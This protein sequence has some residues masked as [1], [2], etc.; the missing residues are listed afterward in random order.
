[1]HTKPRPGRRLLITVH[2]IRTF[3][4]W[5]ERLEA[6]V[7]QQTPSLSV[8]NYKYGYFSLLAFMF[9]PLRWLLT[10]RFQRELLRITTEAKWKR[11][12]I[13]AHSF[14]SH[15]VAWSLLKLA[16]TKGPKINTIIFCGSVL[17]RSFPWGDLVGSRVRRVVNDCGMYDWVLA[18]NQLAVVFTGMAGLVGFSGMTSDYF[19][20][21]WYRFGHS[22]FFTKHGSPDDAFMKRYWVPLLANQRT[23]RP[24]DERGAPGIVSGIIITLLQNAEPIKLSIYAI[25]LLLPAFYFYELK[26]TAE[27]EANI[28]Q[29]SA[30]ASHALRLL[31]QDSSRSLHLAAR[32]F[33][34]HPSTSTHQ[35]LLAARYSNP[36]YTIIRD[37]S[38]PLH[39]VRIS[40][41]GARIAA[42]EGDGRLLL[43]DT[44]GTEVRGL[45]IKGV[46]S[47]EWGPNGEFIVVST[48]E[49]VIVLTRDGVEVYSIDTSGATFA[50]LGFDQDLVLIAAKKGALI[51]NRIESKSVSLVGHQQGINSVR[52]SPKGDLVVTASKD[53]TVRVWSTKGKE[54]FRLE[55]DSKTTDTIGSLHDR[56]TTI[57][58]IDGED[59]Y[60][61][62]RRTRRG[63]LSVVNHKHSFLDAKFNFE[64]TLIATCSTDGTASVWNYSEDTVRSIRH[65]DW[66]S[67]VAFV[68]SSGMLATASLDTTAR[69]WNFETSNVEDLVGHEDF[70]HAIDVLP[71]GSAAITASEDGTL[72]LWDLSQPEIYMQTAP[73]P[74]YL[75][76]PLEFGPNGTSVFTVIRTYSEPQGPQGWRM[77]RYHLLRTEK[78]QKPIV[79]E[80]SRWMYNSIAISWD[81]EKVATT[82]YMQGSATVRDS[83]GPKHFGVGEQ[84]NAQCIAISPGNSR[85]VVGY[86]GGQMAIFDLESSAKVLSV[87]AHQSGFFACKFSPSGNHILTASLDN[88]AKVWTIRGE[89]VACLEGHD[90]WV[91]A[92]SMD[93]ESRIAATASA[94][95][96]ARLWNLEGEEI[97]RLAGHTESVTDIKISPRKNYVLTASADRTARLWDPAGLQ[98]GAFSRG[99]ERILAIEFIGG[100][101]Q[102]LI[103]FEDGAIERWSIDGEHILSALGEDFLENASAVTRNEMQKM[104][105][106]LQ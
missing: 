55:G 30:I 56:E 63:R 2:G 15:L 31:D 85:I 53:N 100:D 101:R 74:E 80:S 61:T 54:L 104:G 8:R 60:T 69:L 22:G 92:V 7:R 3:G 68:G 37:S 17:K 5:Q 83:S 39:G 88:T 52:F 40:P 12:D 70:I 24:H 65:N 36:L 4:N 64:G 6:L 91:Q 21:R 87:D 84:R 43:L 13:V 1:M 89:L 16:R 94:D 106:V 32:A 93:S 62:S 9:P 72:R 47:T 14:G 105:V 71:D 18:L 19:R 29:A 102:V 33:Q 51:H 35:T 45:A 49:K 78:G 97:L 86:S 27:E 90:G 77:P 98:L 99:E 76:V 81:E 75:E 58:L 59:Q 46:N 103:A 25:V 41:D 95:K 73:L 50:H 67:D 26:T 48:Y 44:D 57:A 20:N 42:I 79:L 96:T 11:I 28:A 38:T 66:V 34:I 10:L 23:I 82:R